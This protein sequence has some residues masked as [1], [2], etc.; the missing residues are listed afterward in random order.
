MY[1][2][3]ACNKNLIDTTNKENSIVIGM[4]HFMFSPSYLDY[5]N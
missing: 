5:P 1:V 2:P 3:W 4:S